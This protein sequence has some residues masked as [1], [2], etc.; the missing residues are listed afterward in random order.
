MQLR[1]FGPDD[2]DAITAFVEIENARIAAD[3]PW[4]HPLT[5]YRQEMWMRYGWDGEPVRCF[6]VS[7]HDD[8]PVGT[9]RINTAEWDNLELAWL[10]L[11]IHPDHRR[12]GHGS[13]A[14]AAL[15]DECRRLGR[16]LVGMDGWDDD[17]ARGFSAAVGYEK[18]SQSINRRQD[19]RDLGAH[20]FEAAYAEA[21]PMA[22]DY[23]LERIAGPSPDDLHDELS[24]VT[25]SINDAPLDD[26]E[27]E[28]EVYTPQRI[29]AFEHAQTEGG[30]R[31]YRVLVR[32]RSTRELAG[33]TV[34]TVDRERPELGAQE[35]TTVVRS[36]RGHRLGLLL[37]AD[38]CR[39]LIDVEPG[40]R[41]LD[42][43]NAESN[44]HMI[45]VNERLG[46]RALGRGLEFQ[47][48]V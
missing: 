8:E 31:L 1:E 3:S 37:K 6:L 11:S 10:G 38:L 5:P 12:Q 7:D 36:H 43:W 2:A 23:E 46:Y 14:V 45:A 48:R 34:V 33:H 16:P 41:S 9:A 20:F 19:L 40:L 44:D 29:R 26:L 25:A 13:A 18:K 47:R 39:W 28:D 42:T 22:H 27:I 35:D 17:A 32:H 24:T 30:N 15:H 21:E 4:Q